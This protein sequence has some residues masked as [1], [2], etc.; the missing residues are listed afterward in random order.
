[1]RPFISNR[2]FPVSVCNK[3]MDGLDPRIRRYFVDRYKDHWKIHD[4]DATYQIAKLEEIYLAAIGAE[5]QYRTMNATAREAVGQPIGQTYA[6]TSAYPSQAENTLA[7]YDSSPSHSPRRSKNHKC[8]GCGSSDHSWQ[9]N[10]IV[11]CPKKD[12][13]AVQ[14]AAKEGFQKYRDALR[15]RER[16]KKESPTKRALSYADLD[17]EAKKKMA[18]EVFQAHGTDAASV[19]SSVTSPTAGSSSP[20][21]RIHRTLYCSVPVPEE[22][23]GVVPVLAAD[24]APARRILPVVVTNAFPT[25]ELPVGSPEDSQFPAIKCVVD[26]AAGLTTGNILYLVRLYAPHDY[27]PIVLSGIVKS[28]KDDEQFATCELDCAFEFHLPFYSRD[29]ATISLIIA[30]G[31]DV[32]VNC[33]LGLPFLKGSGG[34]VDLVNDLV[35]LCHLDCA[36]FKLKML[37]PSCYVPEVAPPSADDRGVVQFERVITEI[38]NLVA[39]VCGR[40]ATQLSGTDRLVS[41]GSNSELGPSQ[42]RSDRSSGAPPSIVRWTPHV[43]DYDSS[44][45]YHDPMLLG[46]SDS[47]M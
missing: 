6:M 20:V 19:A 28:T 41:F 10:G 21:S 39:H 18:Q 24:G 4:L 1:M 16:A 11:T 5:E 13:P 26:T 17:D 34:I 35:E 3:F 31:P 46:N 7:R 45:S 40:S 23:D 15:K 14:R 36:P 42:P 2:T 8:F 44:S 29:G 22:V 47:S 37:R 43:S 25:I 30:T 27:R 12:D 38:D 9:T 33:I 32:S